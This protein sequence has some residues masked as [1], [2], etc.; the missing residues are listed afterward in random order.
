MNYYSLS[1]KTANTRENF[2]N[3]YCFKTNQMRDETATGNHLTTAWSSHDLTRKNELAV[4]PSTNLHVYRYQM[5]NLFFFY[6][7]LCIRQLEI[8]MN[9]ILRKSDVESS[10]E[11]R[12]HS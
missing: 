4:S 12:K 2:W 8:D 5:L 10:R 3:V 6:S 11:D 7:N 1:R 9:D